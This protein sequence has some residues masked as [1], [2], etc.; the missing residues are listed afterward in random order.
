MKNNET[1][2]YLFMHPSY[3]WA[4]GIGILKSTTRNQP[5]LL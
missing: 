3:K 1:D 4:L 5:H 2:L